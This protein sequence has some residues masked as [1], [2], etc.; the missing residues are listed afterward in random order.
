MITATASRR[1]PQAETIPTEATALY[2]HC[3]EMLA[4]LARFVASTVR[5]ADLDEL[6]NEGFVAL[7]KAR[8]RFDARR[9]SFNTFAHSV[10]YPAMR[11]YALADHY[12]LAVAQ[13]HR[14]TSR[15][16][17]PPRHFSILESDAAPV[18]DEEERDSIR[19]ARKLLDSLIPRER[20]RVQAYLDDG[21]NFAAV[22]RRLGLSMSAVSQWFKRFFAHQR[23]WRAVYDSM[24]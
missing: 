9:A 3:R 13:Y 15:S 8:P 23:K 4:G 7:L 12:G 24:M 11:R 10:V 17:A 6:V 21:G 18:A 2:E 14:L 16:L 20:E 19:R 5:P 1:L 22:G